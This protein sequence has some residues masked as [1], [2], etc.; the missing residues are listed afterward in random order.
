LATFH[1]ILGTDSDYLLYEAT[2]FC[3]GQGISSL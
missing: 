3:S 2:G 1:K